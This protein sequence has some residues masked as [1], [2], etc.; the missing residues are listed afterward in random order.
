[1]SAPIRALIIDPD[2]R[3]LANVAHVLAHRGF[4]I[5]ARR[6]AE[7]AIDYV[8]RSRPDVVLLGVALWEEGWGTQILAAAP[9]T[10]VVP[11]IGSPDAPWNKEAA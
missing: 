1:M 2:P 9:E 5:T 4:R 3:V 8:R 7:E 11:V 10:V 6:S